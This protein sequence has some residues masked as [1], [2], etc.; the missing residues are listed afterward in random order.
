MYNNALLILKERYILVS[1]LCQLNEYYV[2]CMNILHARGN[3]LYANELVRVKNLK[4][5]NISINI[6]YMKIQIDEKKNHNYV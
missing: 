2:R 3:N 4:N 6:N 5:V 1:I